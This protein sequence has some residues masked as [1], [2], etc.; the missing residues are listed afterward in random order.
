[1]CFFKKRLC[2][3]FISCAFLFVSY[4]G[5]I[6]IASDIKNGKITVDKTEGV[7]PSVSVKVK[8]IPDEGYDLES[9]TVTQ[10]NGKNVP[11][12]GNEFQMPFGDVTITA[13]FKKPVE[14]KSNPDSIGDVVLNDGTV[15]AYENIDKMNMAQKSK[16]IA[17]IFYIGTDC[18]NNGEMRTLGVGLHHG[19]GSWD[20]NEVEIT[21]AISVNTS[22]KIDT[23]GCFVSVKTEKKSINNRKKENIFIC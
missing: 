2:M 19:T 7:M 5:S 16:A 14:T 22:P 4:A 10:K 17:V 23:V 13:T 18:S 21:K 1:M 20:N 6:K 12:I 15:V 9:L 11:V 8:S 3:I